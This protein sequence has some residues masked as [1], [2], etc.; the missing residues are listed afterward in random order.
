MRKQSEMHEQQVRRRVL[1]NVLLRQQ[2]HLRQKL[3]LLPVQQ[4]LLQLAE[5][6][7]QFLHRQI[8]RGVG[9]QQIVQ[10]GIFGEFDGRQRF[11]RRVRNLLGDFRILHLRQP[12][13]NV[14]EMLRQQMR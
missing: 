7:Q 6:R 8:L 10:F 11:R 4:R 14:S 12:V 3:V 5:M 13:R 9:V 2:P 1:R